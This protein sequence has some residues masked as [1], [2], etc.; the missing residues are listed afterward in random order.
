MQKK[1]FI[2]ALIKNATEKSGKKLQREV[3]KLRRSLTSF[4][5][6]LPPVSVAF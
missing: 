6:L 5:S 2:V 4:S 1:Q 3:S